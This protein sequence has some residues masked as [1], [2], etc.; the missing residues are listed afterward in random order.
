[1]PK[2]FKCAT[3]F[4]I[5]TVW[6]SLTLTLVILF[7]KTV[8]AETTPPITTSTVTPSAPDGINGWYRT[9]V[10]FD[11]E[12]TDLD[13]GIKEIRYRIDNGTWQ[14]VPFTNSGNLA[15]NPSFETSGATTSGVES[16]EATLVD[17][18]VTH[19][20]DTTTALS[21]FGTSSAKM[22]ATAGTWHGINNK[23]FYA[24][25]TPYENMSASVWL[26]TTNVVGTAGFKV[27]TVSP[28]GLGGYVYQEVA[29]SATLSGTNNWTRLNLN[30]IANASDAVGVYIDIGLVGAGTVWVDAV[31]LNSSL[32]AATTSVTVATDSEDHTFAFYSVDNEDNIETYSCTSPVKNCYT[33]KLDQ[34]PP[35]NWRDSGAWR[36]FIGPAYHLWVYATVDDETSGLRVFSDKYQIHTETDPGYGVHNDILNCNST[37]QENNWTILIT[38][39]FTPGVNS[40]YLLTPKTSFCNS[41]WNQCKITRFY[42]EDMAGNPSTKDFCING[43]W[44]NVQGKAAVRANANIDMLAEADG[45]NTDGLIETGGTAVDFFTS[46]EDWVAKSIVSPNA[47]NYSDL[48]DITPEKTPIS[49]N[50]LGASSGVFSITG[51]M[52]L[53]RNDMPS[54]YQSLTFNKIIF[55]S[56]NMT[57][58][59]DIEVSD[60]STLL[61]VVQ[62][63]VLIDKTVQDVGFAIIADGIIDTAYNVTEG[64]GTPTLHFRGFYVADEFVLSHTLLGTQNNDNPSEDFTYEPKYLIQLKQFFN[65]SD[66]FWRYIQ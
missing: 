36:G 29:Q 6:T 54:N 28:D 45:D 34:T 64:D 40:A 53:Q 55:V 1:M 24:T 33:F 41:N 8:Y 20:Q 59:Q 39:P 11:L 61:F 18:D 50:D 44:I 37:W 47:L 2:L 5:L 46:S 35:T 58:S 48:W 65:T 12:A 57:I 66:T 56:G 17:A 38:P 25:A 3:S 10:R 31:T 21:G 51:D 22:V 23:S 63:D 42:V 14:I 43:P 60:S 27:Y 26:K 30:F 52:T 9:P 19:T 15:L 16:W 4:K 62:G 7:P 13:S 49:E 32:N